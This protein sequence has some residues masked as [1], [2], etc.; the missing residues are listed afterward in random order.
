MLLGAVHFPA[1]LVEA[2]VEVV[3]LVG[4]GETPGLGLLGEVGVHDDLGDGL[5]DGRVDRVAVHVDVGGLDGRVGGAWL[6][7]QLGRSRGGGGRGGRGG[8]LRRCFD[9][10]GL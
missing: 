9:L 7:G 10:D 4:T 3:G 5:A 6:G 8:L 2:V 1:E